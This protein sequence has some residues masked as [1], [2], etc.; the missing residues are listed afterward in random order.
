MRRYPRF[1][2]LRT[3]DPDYPDADSRQRLRIDFPSDP[4]YEPGDRLMVTVADEHVLPE[5]LHR[6]DAR[7]KFRSHELELDRLEA[8]WLHEQLGKLLTIWRKDEP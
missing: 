7:V 3:P 5:Q 4:G 1:C 2:E 6:P 8:V